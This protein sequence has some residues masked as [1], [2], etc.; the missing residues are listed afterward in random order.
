MI[1]LDTNAVVRILT[2]GDPR[3]V[4]A[5]RKLL[6]GAHEAP[7][8]FHIN[9]VVLAECAWALK[10]AYRYTREEIAIGIEGLLETPV[11]DI[12][13]AELV[14]QALRQFRVSTADFP[15][16]LI[17]AKNAAAGCEFTVSFD[18]AMLKLP[19]VKPV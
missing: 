8:S 7:A 1:G 15:D 9:H 17:A 19:G 12:E 10:A 3:Q 14:I 2:G 4:A 18:K 6:A 13:E 16:C 11:L 5:V